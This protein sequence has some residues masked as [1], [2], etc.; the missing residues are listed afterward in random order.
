MNSC[1]IIRVVFTRLQDQNAILHIGDQFDLFCL[2]M[3]LSYSL[4]IRFI[5]PDKEIL[6]AYFFFLLF[7]YSL[8]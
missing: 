8:I 2:S 3:N 4:H 1:A 7:S 6:L 5:G